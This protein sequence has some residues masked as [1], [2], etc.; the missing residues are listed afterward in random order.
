MA[1]GENFRTGANRISR[2]SRGG[3]G[4]TSVDTST[5]LPAFSNSEIR[6]STLGRIGASTRR[7]IRFWFL[8]WKGR[9]ESLPLPNSML[10][11]TFSVRGAIMVVSFIQ[12]T[13]IHA[14]K[15]GNNLKIFGGHGLGP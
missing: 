6:G 10:F 15:Q 5:V 4:T 12:P 14:E 8:R 9:V 13:R 11:G 3:S 1:S 7:K 2:A